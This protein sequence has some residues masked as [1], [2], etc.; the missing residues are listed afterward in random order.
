MQA[1]EIGSSRQSNHVQPPAGCTIQRATELDFDKAFNLVQEYFDLIDVWVRDTRLEFSKYLA[2]DNGGIW[3]ALDGE[4]PVGCIAL[5]PLPFSE[6]SGEVKRLYVKNPYRRQGLADRLLRALEQYA[7][8]LRYEWLYLDSKDDLV[9]A[10]R[11]YE[12]RGYRLCPRYNHNPQA[13]IFMRK[14]VVNPEESVDTPKIIVR[15]F[16]AEDA[17]AFRRLNEEW[18]TRY[19]RLE[20]KDMKTLENPAPYILEPGGYIGMAFAGE[21]AVG[22][23]ALL[24]LEHDVFEVAKM[25]VAPAWQGRGLGR[26]V[27]EHVIGKA[28]ELGARRLYLETN[29]RLTPAIRLYESVGFHQVPPEK[30]TPSP[31]ERADVFM[32]MDLEPPDL[33][34]N[35][36][37]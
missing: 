32:E 36:T 14:Q 26:R 11:F 29:S 24:R 22:C 15:S 1:K 2:T 25:A 20:D 18:I 12:R 35:S 34:R 10:I 6:R 23:C 21:E 4:Q 37:R 5:H 9:E 30:V 13:T 3:L 16:R 7:A 27:L 8:E 33:S 31:Y 17:T 19:F 28:H